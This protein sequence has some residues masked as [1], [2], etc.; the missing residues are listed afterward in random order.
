MRPARPA[1]VAGCTEKSGAKDGRPHDTQV[2]VAL[3]YL[4]P[5]L[6]LLLALTRTP[7]KEPVRDGA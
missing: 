1:S 3:L 2:A 6:A 7:V 5:A 4:I